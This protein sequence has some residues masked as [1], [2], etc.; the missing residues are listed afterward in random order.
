MRKLLKKAISQRKAKDLEY[1]KAKK[2]IAE[3]KEKLSQLSDYFTQQ[4][5]I[6][7]EVE[8]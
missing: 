3:Q 6:L 8:I 4:E 2:I 7:G 5:K 1:C